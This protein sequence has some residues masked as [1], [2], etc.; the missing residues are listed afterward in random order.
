MTPHSA[1]QGPRKRRVQLLPWCHRLSSSYRMSLPDPGHL[2]CCVGSGA[3]TRE[4]V[5]WPCPE[6]R[7]CGP[8][9]EQRPLGSVRTQA[10]GART[11]DFTAARRDE[12]Q[13]SEK[14]T[15]PGQRELAR[16]RAPPGACPVIPCG[17]EVETDIRAHIDGWGMRGRNMG[18]CLPGRGF[19]GD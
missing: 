4:S 17:A 3:D 7:A 6:W 11:Q 18:V 9:G 5:A 15:A 10:T 13:W 8:E 14:Q 16:Q 1:F 19:G 2:L 12:T